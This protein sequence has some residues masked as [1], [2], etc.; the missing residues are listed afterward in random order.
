MTDTFE[1]RSKNLQLS[2]KK[3]DFFDKLLRAKHIAVFFNHTNCTMIN[4]RRSG[5]LE[6][7]SYFQ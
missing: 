7:L 2:Y 4:K 6:K 3:P 5:S 1:N